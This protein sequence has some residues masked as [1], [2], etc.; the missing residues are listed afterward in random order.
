MK[1]L[2]CL[3][4]ISSIALPSIAESSSDTYPKNHDIDAINYAFH[5]T[6]SDETDVIK[7]TTVMDLRFLVAGI[8]TVRLDLSNKNDDTDGKGMTV[9]RIS[10]NDEI[11]NYVHENDA[12][13]ITLPSPSTTNQRSSITIEYVG[14]P[15]TGLKI[16][17]NKYDERTFFSDN[18]PNKARNWLPTIDHPY[19]K[20]MCEFVVTAPNHYQVISNGLKMEETDIDNENRLTHWKQSVPIAT[21]LFVLGVSRFAVQHVDDFEGLAIE[22]WV[23]PQDRDAGFYDF[24]VPTKAAMAFYSDMVGPYSYEKL[25]NIQSNSVGG[26]MEAATAIFYGDRSVT[27]QRSER[28]RNVIIHEVAHQWFGNAVTETDWDDVW[29]SEGFA[30]YFTL[31]F[32]EHAY[33]RDE[34]VK[35]L[36]NSKMRIDKFDLNNPEYRIIHDNLD[37][38][39]KVTTGQTYQKGAWVLHMLRN[40][41]S[42]DTFWKGIQSYY[43]EYKDL[44]ASTADFRRHM[45]EA[46]GM[47]LK[48]FFDQWLRRGGQPSLDVSWAYDSEEKKL[49]LSVDQTQV[50]DSFS[51]PLEIGVVD[52]SGE[53][54]VFRFDIDQRNSKHSLEIDALPAKVLLDPMVTLLMHG[55]IE[56][57]E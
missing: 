50:A 32:I 48:A 53:M 21:W 44:N 8:S 28:W 57:K 34:F 47:D 23:Y 13:F 37:D 31:L 43:A 45:E 30:T 1:F 11:L 6:L 26:G 20:A 25:A 5:F 38:M 2:T 55:E 7:G 51:F 16:A 14:I 4:L 46:S 19:D 52:S 42:T 35:G 40:L 33:G 29:L 17:P 27:G 15:I 36:K 10:M 18:W 49:N 41:V 9:N 24:A 56:E 39:S 54:E 22:T 12:L 3:V